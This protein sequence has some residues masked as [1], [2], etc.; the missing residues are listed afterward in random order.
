MKR[1]A[2][3]YIIGLAM[4]EAGIASFADLAGRL[5]V[6]TAYLSQIVNGVERPP[7]QQ[8]RIAELLGREPRDLFGR[9]THPTLTTRR[10]RLA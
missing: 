6:S 2:V 3:K 9:W 10:G 5:G 8:R 1:E 4:V 7:A